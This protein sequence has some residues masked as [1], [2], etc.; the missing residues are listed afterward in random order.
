MYIAYIVFGNRNAM[1][2]LV[3]TI[4]SAYDLVTT[5]M[6][7]IYLLL[8]VDDQIPQI[9]FFFFFLSK[10]NKH[11]NVVNHAKRKPSCVTLCRSWRCIY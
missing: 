9:V 10:K 3:I 5:Y 2:H 6:W 1:E 8:N 4:V 11:T 7:N